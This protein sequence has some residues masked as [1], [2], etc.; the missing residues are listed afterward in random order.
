MHHGTLESGF[1][2]IGLYCI[3]HTIPGVLNR[4]ASA[5]FEVGLKLTH[6]EY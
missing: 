3:A 1:K 4:G 2:T 6:D 5:D